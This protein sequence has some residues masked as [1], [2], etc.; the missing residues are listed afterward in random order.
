MYKL[1]A[2]LLTIILLTGSVCACGTKKNTAPTEN[3]VS[4]TG[5]QETEPPVDPALPEVAFDLK[6]RCADGYTM[7]Q[8]NDMTKTDY[9]A[10]VRYYLE[11]GYR[12]YSVSEI[13]GIFSTTLIGDNDYKT[14]TFNTAKSELYLGASASGA[15]LPSKTELG[16]KIC[17]VTITQKKSYEINGMGYI[18]RLEDGSFIVV[19]GGYVQDASLLYD[20][21]CRL[22]GSKDGIH[23][24]AW[25]ITHSHD[26]HCQAFSK[27]AKDHGNSVKLDY[28]I[29]SPIMYSANNPPYLTKDYKS[30]LEKFDGAVFCGAHTGMVFS[31]GE[32]RIEILFGP[33]HNYK[34]DAPS[35]SNESSMVFRFV[36]GDGS[37]TVLGD[38]GVRSCDWMVDSYGEA[39]KS[40]MVQISH[41]GCETATAE[42]YD[43]I[44]AETC[45]WPC[46]ESLMASYRG[47][48]VKQHIIEAEYSKIHLLHSYQ[49]ITKPLSYKA[50]TPKYLDILPT[51]AD[52]IS[53]S[54]YVKKVRVENGVLKFDTISIKNQFDPYISFVLD[55]VD[56][57][58]YNAIRIVA[59]SETCGESSAVFFTCGNDTALKFTANKSSA[60]GVMGAS[61]DGTT[62]YIAY[63][64]D[65]KG[66]CSG[67][68]SSIRLDFGAKGGQTVEIYSVELFYLD[69][70]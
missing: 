25:L 31:F 12:E 2:L 60:L 46:S 69:V 62:T 13:G 61:D 27:F 64:A 15:I 50:K 17:D 30:D 14:V 63:L 43:M 70:N 41:H 68:L 3:G 55:N 39:L 51:S 33:E 24:R 54:A 28:F 18:L 4:T 47:E 23:I 10:A 59:K 57:A 53:A 35:D 29:T 19:D 22:N 11:G 1:T 37:M 21:L 5:P 38:C 52:G 20:A 40:D 7:D 67:K 34:K 45:F 44:A 32:L 42:L 49:D 56:T 6:Y 26:D 16:D 8:H 48:L 66:G 9:R 65:I 58:E 36:N